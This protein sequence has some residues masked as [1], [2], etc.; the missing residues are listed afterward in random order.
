MM[1][2]RWKT[3]FLATIL[4]LSFL[5]V[6]ES[7]WAMLRIQSQI[8]VSVQLFGYSGLSEILLGEAELAAGQSHTVEGTYRGLAIL[9]PAGGPSFP[10]LLGEETT[11]LLFEDAAGPPS[12]PGSRSNT[13]FY[14]MLTGGQQE[15]GEADEF[16]RLMLQAKDLLE[17]SYAIRSTAEAAAKSAEFYSFV[18][19]H[20]RDLR[21]SDMV[22]RLVAQSLMMLEYVDYHVAGAPAG[23]I[24]IRHRQAIVEGVA[25]WLEVLGPHMSSGEI[26]DFCVLF[27][28]RRGMV[29][30]AGNIVERFRDIAS[31][32]GVEDLARQ[33]PAD[34]LLTNAEKTASVR[35]SAL[36]GEK[37]FAFVSE[38]C[39]VSMVEA[40]LTARRLAQQGNVAHLIVVPREPLSE[41]HLA[42]NSMVSNGAML[43]V[44]DQ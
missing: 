2:K 10:V 33:I 40:V 30:M 6:A 18:G 4:L 24:A 23:D 44:T 13:S 39:A 20:Y 19:E 22:R 43:F 42:M 32:P 25:G 9:T 12:F 16:A 14:A 37:I 26:V 3:P 34:T 17:S 36:K 15:D 5:W 31:C 21:H 11:T 29:A 28:Y 38:N 8:P 41:S 7:A 1:Q 35:L 27:Y